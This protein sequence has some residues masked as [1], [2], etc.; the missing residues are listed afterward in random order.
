MNYAELRKSTVATALCLMSALA[1]LIL[2][3]VT[4]HSAELSDQEVLKRLTTEQ[5]RDK[6][7][8]RGL[9]Y[10]RQQQRPDGSCS[11]RYP[12]ALT[13]MAIM[14]HFAA[15]HPPADKQYG[16]WLRKSISYVISKQS[17]DG[18]FGQADGSRKECERR[19]GERPDEP[20]PGG[21]TR[22]QRMHIAAFAGA[23]ARKTT[24]YVSRS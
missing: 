4:L 24:L 10:L 11:E 3:R 9:E 14:A 19:A 20:E 8:R 17:S 23:G 7:V 2:G 5:P 13:A 18:Y 21:K 12:T 22:L 15:G 16:P 1:G 6:A